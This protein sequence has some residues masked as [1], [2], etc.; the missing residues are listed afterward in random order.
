M[1]RYYTSSESPKPWAASAYSRL[2]GHTR[3]RV[4]DTLDSPGHRE[5]SVDDLARRLAIEAQNSSR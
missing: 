1:D 3:D 2:G 5:T 4:D